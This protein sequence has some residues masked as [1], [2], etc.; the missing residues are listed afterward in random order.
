MARRR[1]DRLCYLIV[2]QGTDDIAST[3]LNEMA[4][5]IKIRFLGAQLYVFA[6]QRQK[7]ALAQSQRTSN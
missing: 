3:G 5:H 4:T 6:M 1:V 2:T 7:F